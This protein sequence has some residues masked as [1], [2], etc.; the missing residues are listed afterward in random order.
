MKCNI[1]G[2][3]G[4]KVHVLSGPGKSD[5]MIVL[6]NIHKK[7]L[8]RWQRKGGRQ[9]LTPEELD[10]RITAWHDAPSDSYIAQ[11]ELHEYLGWSWEQYKHWVETGELNGRQV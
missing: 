1:C 8:K 11:M 7:G 2:A 6:C 5:K 10:A 9:P 3:P 4:N